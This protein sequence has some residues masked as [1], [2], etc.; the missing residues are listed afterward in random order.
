VR[1]L[2][3]RGCR[4]VRLLGVRGCRVMRVLGDQ[5]WLRMWI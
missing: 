3:V 4:V 1:L 2:G 5:R